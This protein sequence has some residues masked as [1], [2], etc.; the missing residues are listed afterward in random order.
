MR[1]AYASKLYKK[2]SGSVVDLLKEVFID[3]SANTE[4]STI[5]GL[6]FTQLPGTFDKKELH[7]PSTQISSFL[8]I[9]PRI[10]RV[11]DIGGPSAMTMLYEAIRAV[12]AGM[13][14][15]ILCVVGGKGS[16]L[17]EKGFTADSVDKVLPYSITPYDELFR[18]YDDMNPVTDYALVANR[19]KFLYHSTDEERATISV[20]QRKN[21][22]SN[23]KA[24]YKSPLSVKEVLSSRMIADPLRLLEVVYPIDGFNLFLVGKGLT[25]DYVDVSVEF[26]R[27]AHWPEMP[28]D[29]DLDVT[30]TPAL[31][32]GKGVN[33]D[34]VDALE[35]YDSFTIT[36]LLQ[37]EDLGLAKK[38]DGGKFFEE[39][40]VSPTGEIPVNTGGGTLNTGQPAFMSGG[41]ILE[42][43]IEQL[44]GRAM[45]RQVKGVQRVLINGIGGWNRAHS[46]TMVLRG[47]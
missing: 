33:L 12:E 44:G 46:V 22:E 39:K 19:H 36:V 38:G 5:D 8:G 6:F 20:K 21:A 7:F 9:K 29:R 23:P 18:I 3:L 1:V 16:M 27:E 41:V 15:K 10:L 11:L 13:A 2:Y 25:G 14:E 42:E 37:V 31:E 47:E 30:Y 24:I 45:G 32:S 35:L 43:A 40:D 17:R 34:K 4:T 28:P 26:Y